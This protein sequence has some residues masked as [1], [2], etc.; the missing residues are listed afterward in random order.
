[1]E[2]AQRVIKGFAIA[3]AVM[4]IVSIVSVCV[5]AGMIFSR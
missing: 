2:G 1:M 3:F 4:I 5:G